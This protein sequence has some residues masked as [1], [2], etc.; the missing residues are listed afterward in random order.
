MRHLKARGIYSRNLFMPRSEETQR[1]LPLLGKVIP[2][3]YA[4]AQVAGSRCR[5]ERRGNPAMRFRPMPQALSLRRLPASAGKPSGREEAGERSAGSLKSG[6][7]R[8]TPADLFPISTRYSETKKNADF[9]RKRRVRIF[10][11]CCLQPFLNTFRL[12]RPRMKS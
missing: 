11:W 4:M 6:S 12:H 10:V 9:P 7:L 3:G 8:A 1:L 2:A 5:R